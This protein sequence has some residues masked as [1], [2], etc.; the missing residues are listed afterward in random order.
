[1]GYPSASVGGSGGES[2]RRRCPAR[3]STRAPSRRGRLARRRRGRRPPRRR[4]GRP[5]ARPGRAT[6]ACASVPR[7]P[8]SSRVAFQR[9]AG[10]GT[11]AQLRIGFGEDVGGARKLRQQFPKY[12]DLVAHRESLLG[13]G[14]ARLALVD[15]AGDAVAALADRVGDRRRDDAEASGPSAR[16]ASRSHSRSPSSGRPTGTSTK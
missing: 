11:A 15:T 13:E 2:R 14:L 3:P 9:R 16:R 12:R 8:R 10:D 1:M 7:S 6:R 4:P 5:A